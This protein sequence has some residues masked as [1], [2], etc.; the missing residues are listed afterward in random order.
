MAISHTQLSA[1]LLYSKCVHKT[2]GRLSQR[3][4][5]LLWYTDTVFVWTPYSSINVADNCLPRPPKSVISCLLQT[6]D[7]HLHEY[8]DFLMVF[9]LF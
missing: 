7:H 6:E 8:V 5:F 2:L 4:Y 9:K 1:W 3:C